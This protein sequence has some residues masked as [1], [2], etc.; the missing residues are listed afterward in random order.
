MNRYFPFE[1][2]VAVRF[3]R[4]GLMQTLLI[5]AGVALGVAVITF[6]SALLS[7]LQANL[8]RRTLNYQPQ[9]VVIPPEDVARPLREPGSERSAAIVQPRTQ[10]LRSVDQWQ[11]VR[12]LVE[13][14][15]DVVAVAPVV[16]GPGT[17]RVGYGPQPGIQDCAKTDFVSGIIAPPPAR[18]MRTCSLT[19][20]CCIGMCPYASFHAFLVPFHMR[21]SSSRMS[22]PHVDRSAASPASARSTRATVGWSERC[23]PRSAVAT[24]SSIRPAPI[25]MLRAAYQ[26]VVSPPFRPA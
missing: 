21:V 6:M 25:G 9:I 19:H 12:N 10:R 7:G 13:Q 18:K 14:L 8:F 2:I 1:W 20:R 24:I 3:M 4:D 26:I 11:K 15:P 23:E 17:T 5:V 16:S 22:C